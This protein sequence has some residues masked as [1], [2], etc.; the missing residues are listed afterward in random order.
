MHDDQV[1]T[2]AYIVGSILG[3]TFST[4]LGGEAV[5]GWY[6]GEVAPFRRLA[7]VSRAFR[8]IGEVAPVLASFAGWPLYLALS[9]ACVLSFV[10]ANWYVGTKY[11]EHV[12]TKKNG[13]LASDREE[14]K[15]ALKKSR[16]NE[17]CRLLVNGE[18]SVMRSSRLNVLHERLS[19]FGL[20]PPL[21]DETSDAV[22]HYQRMIPYI[23][24]YGL[25]RAKQEARR[26]LKLRKKIAATAKLGSIYGTAKVS[27]RAGIASPLQICARIRALL[28][29]VVKRESGT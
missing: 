25:A 17:F 9:V 26:L 19:D 28:R 4:F 1:R 12:R 11:I 13:R 6:F 18:D 29:N 8:R 3:T 27:K 23:E 5:R 15:D 24:E 22:R 20:S 10:A 2:F 7:T 21:D 14:A 16:L